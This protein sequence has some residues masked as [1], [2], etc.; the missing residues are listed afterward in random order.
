MKRV[1]IAVAAVAFAFPAFA[2]GGTAAQPSLR[3]LKLTPPSVLGTHFKAGEKVGVTFRSGTTKIVRTVRVSGRGEFTVVFGGVTQV[4]RCG[5]VPVSLVAVGAGGEKI[6][7]KLP[8]TGCAPGGA[9]TP[10][11]G[12][13]PAT[14]TTTPYL[15]PPPPY[16]S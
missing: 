9:A 2:A 4:D 3:L 13:T 8:R 7:V 12:G 15:A 10:P 5:L 16:T 1:S 11:A 6:V 14:T